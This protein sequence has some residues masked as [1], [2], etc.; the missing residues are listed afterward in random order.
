MG[1]VVEPEFGDATTEPLELVTVHWYVFVGVR[2][3]ALN[4][5][6]MPT[7]AELK[8]AETTGQGCV[9]K[10]NGPIHEL[11]KPLVQLSLR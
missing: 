7:T 11:A 2:F 9:V 1:T 6:F 3:W 8:L 10:F 4:I 5:K